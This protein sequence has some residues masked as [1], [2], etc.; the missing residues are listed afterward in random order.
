MISL[1]RYYY[2]VSYCSLMYGIHPSEL[3]ANHIISHND[4][5]S[6]ILQYH[7]S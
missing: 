3:I 1:T 7:F 2:R 4:N 6:T 5:M